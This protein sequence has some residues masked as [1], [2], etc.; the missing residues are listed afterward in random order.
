MAGERAV[1][2]IQFQERLYTEFTHHFPSQSVRKPDI[3]RHS[4]V[5]FPSISVLSN[6]HSQINSNHS[7]YKLSE[8]KQHIQDNRIFLHL[9]PVDLY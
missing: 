5:E 8:W 1:L 6:S 3:S 2:C 4:T 7:P 9:C